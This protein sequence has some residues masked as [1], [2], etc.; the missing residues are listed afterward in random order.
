MLAIDRSALQLAFNQMMGLDQ[1]DP[2][3][4]RLNHMY[5]IIDEQ[6]QEVQFKLNLVQSLL[7]LNLWYFNVVLKSRQ[8]GITTFA[9]LLALD[10]CISVPNISTAIIAHDIFLAEKFF[11]RNVKHPYDKLPEE[12]KKAIGAPETKNARELLFPNGSSIVVT[13]SGRSG[14]YQFLHVCLAGDTGIYT[15][16]G[17]IKPIQDIVEGDHVL[18][19]K[20]S[21]RIVKKVIKN[22]LQDLNQKMFSVDVF[23]YYEPL[24]LTGNHK[25]LTR[26]ERGKDIGC[27][28]VWKQTSDLKPGDYLALP[29]REP[30]NKTRHGTIKFGETNIEPTFNLGWLS[31]FYLAEGY[32]RSRVVNGTKYPPSEVQYCIH[33]NE[34]ENTIGYIKYI[35]DYLGTPR[36]TAPLIRTCES[37][38]SLTTIITVNSKNLSR[39]LFESFGSKDDKHIPDKVWNWGSEFLKG[40]IKGYFDGDGS[41]YDPRCVSVVSTRRQLI[42]QMRLLLISMRFGVPTIYHSDSGERYGRNCKEQWTLK[43]NGPGN[44]KFRESY[45]LPFPDLNTWAQKWRVENGV[46]PDGRKYW[47]RGRNVYWMRVKNII[48]CDP[49]EFVYDLALDVEPHDYVTVNGIVHNSELGK[50]CA[51]YPEKAEEIRT[52]ALNTVHPGAWV[53]IEGTAEG[54]GG[55]FHEICTRALEMQRKRTPLTQLDYRFHFFPWFINPINKLSHDDASISVEYGYQREYLDKLSGQL[56]VN[57]QF[58]VNELS[59]TQRAWYI[60][61]QQDQGDKMLREHCSTPEEAFQVS[62]EGA[63]YATQMAQAYKDGRITRVPHV[64]GILVDTWWDIGVGDETAIWF[65]QNVGREIHVL[66]YYQM[67]GEGLEYY[68]AI[69][70][71][72]RRDY[73]YLYGVHG[74]PHD[75]AVREWGN[76]AKSR[77]KSADEIGISFTVAPKLTLESGHQNVRRIL[78]ICVFDEEGCT[79]AYK[80]KGEQVQLVG[81]PC[82]EQYRKEWD[83]KRGKWKDTPA[84]DFTIHGA[85]AF[86]TLANLHKWS[87]RVD[88]IQE[89]KNRVMRES[90]QTSIGAIQT[91]RN[92][93][94]GISGNRVAGTG[95]KG[96]V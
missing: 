13:T 76:N 67:S 43:L 42:D 59:K 95:T 60:K 61:K 4:W 72:Y 51:K 22:R 83:E 88:Q 14:T 29:I 41:Y 32:T 40:L 11:R 74:A 81:I 53:I 25:V 66:R 77:I 6:G 57:P 48:E 15:K 65:T 26:G 23:G 52:G 54:K 33:R 16:D 90:M 21:Y 49:Q 62:I 5:Y 34:T 44:W 27:E 37:K 64:P 78:S 28:Y 92:Q 96:I 38:N 50:I 87:T 70:D 73:G 9:C 85:D 75:I 20:G 30:S 80:V 93:V 68:K 94:R 35:E 39:F 24:R 2:R 91:A 56:A 84:E 8:H 86:R 69:L 46:R 36:A 71:D 58:G 1:E 45:G 79:Q 31:G 47:R 12:L 18:T 55:L 19:S 89:A 7:Y 82:L 3:R 63:Y 17:I 10:L